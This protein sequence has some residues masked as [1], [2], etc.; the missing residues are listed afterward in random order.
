MSTTWYPLGEV[1][2]LCPPSAL[3]EQTQWWT[4]SQAHP[5]APQHQ[6]KKNLKSLLMVFKLKCH[7]PF[8]E[9]PEF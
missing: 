2:T 8:I 1:I 3:V 9:R 4:V 7:D 6:S 5:T